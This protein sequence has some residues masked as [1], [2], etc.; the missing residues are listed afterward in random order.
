MTPE[1]YCVDVAKASVAAN[2]DAG[3]VA[4]PYLAPGPVIA[5]R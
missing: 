4:L 1:H 2:L 3:R 5:I